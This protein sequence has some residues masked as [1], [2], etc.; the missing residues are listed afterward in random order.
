MKRVLETSN[1][2][3]GVAA[4]DLCLDAETISDVLQCRITT[5]DHQNISALNP[6]ARCDGMHF[7]SMPGNMQILLIKSYSTMWQP[8][9]LASTHKGSSSRKE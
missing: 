6:G 8:H 9:D 7:P 2:L 3:T 5:W 4:D 1:M